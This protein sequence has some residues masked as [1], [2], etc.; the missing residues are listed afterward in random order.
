MTG[1]HLEVRLPGRFDGDKACAARTSL[2]GRAAAIDGGGEADRGLL[3]EVRRGAHCQVE[4]VVLVNPEGRVDLG[5]KVGRGGGD[6]V[7]HCAGTSFIKRFERE[8]LGRG[9]RFNRGLCVWGGGRAK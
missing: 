8:P 6:A 2:D 5:G 4:L 7:R 1:T 9:Q 3:S